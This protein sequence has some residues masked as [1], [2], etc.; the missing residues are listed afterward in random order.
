M[1]D[2]RRPLLLAH[3]GCG[4]SALVSSNWGSLQESCVIV[5]LRARVG[6]NE[7][8]RSRWDNRL[9]AHTR[10]DDELRAQSTHAFWHLRQT[11]R[12]AVHVERRRRAGRNVMHDALDAAALEAFT[13]SARALVE[14]FWADHKVRKD[15]TRLYPNDA[16][17]VDWFVG[18]TITWTPGPKPAVLGE[19]S[20]RVGWGVAHVSYRRIDPEREWGWRPLDV[21]HHLASRFY[22]FASDAPAVRVT[23]D[24]YSGVY[25][26]VMAYREQ[27]DTPELFSW[28]HDPVGP[29]GTP[30][31]ATTV[32]ALRD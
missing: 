25:R 18:G 13:I 29:V 22:D 9:M 11:L 26:E 1:T 3:C 4:P 10:S 8:R 30:G 17:A 27:T 6:W 19:F 24:F 20:K 21:A 14:F 28:L 12:L 15:G 31:H 2:S 16:R 32:A 7:R 23:A 5:I